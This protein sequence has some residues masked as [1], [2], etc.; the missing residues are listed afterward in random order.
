MTAA[1]LFVHVV[2]AAA[3]RP[4]I[5]LAVLAVLVALVVHPQIAAAF[6][7]GLTGGAS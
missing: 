1:Y 5:S 2:R 4:R 7:A 6:V 3:N